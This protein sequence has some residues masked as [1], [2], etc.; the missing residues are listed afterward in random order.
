[1]VDP[2]RDGIWKICLCHRHGGLP[3]DDANAK[4]NVVHLL[5][6]PPT[7]RSKGMPAGRCRWVSCAAYEGWRDLSTDSLST[8]VT[9]QHRRTSDED[10]RHAVYGVLALSQLAEFSNSSNFESTLVQ[11]S[12]QMAGISEETTYILKAK[13]ARLPKA[14]RDEW[15]AFV[16]A[17]GRRSFVAQWT[18][19]IAC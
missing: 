15:Q 1:M 2:M 14:H 10:H 17:L 6:T 4:L 9:F 13:F 16:G 7:A 5:Y 18:D 11:A 19:A 8:A 12:S 3:C